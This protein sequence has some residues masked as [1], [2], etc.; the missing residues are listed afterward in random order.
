MYGRPRGFLVRSAFKCDDDRIDCL[1]PCGMLPPEGWY[2]RLRGCWMG[3]GI[4]LREWRKCTGDVKADDVRRTLQERQRSPMNTSLYPLRT[5]SYIPQVCASTFPPHPSAAHPHHQQR[6][7]Q[8]FPSTPSSHPR[9]VEHA[10]DGFKDRQ[11]LWLEETW[12]VRCDPAW[13]FRW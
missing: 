2:E 6:H 3:K 9:K 8:S 7:S 11:R 13:I 10:V 12:D 1:C 4:C 5:Q